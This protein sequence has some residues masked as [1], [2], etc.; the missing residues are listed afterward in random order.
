MQISLPILVSLVVVVRNVPLEF[1]HKQRL[2]FLATPFVSDG[3]FDL[4][5]SKS[6]AIVEFDE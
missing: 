4:H 6:S 5:L 3:V 2:A 1:I